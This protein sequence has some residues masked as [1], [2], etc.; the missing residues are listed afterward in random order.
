MQSQLTSRAMLLCGW[1]VCL[2]WTGCAKKTA[3]PETDSSASSAPIESE[4]EPDRSGDEVALQEAA[5]QE[6]G[7]NQLDWGTSKGTTSVAK[8]DRGVPL[9]ENGVGSQ[10]CVTC[11]P[12]RAQTFFETTHAKSLRLVDAQQEPELK[13]FYHA[14]SAQRM[15]VVR[16]GELVRHQSW[17]ELPQTDY[18]M[19]LA[20]H[21]I[22]LVMGS[23]TFAKSY[24]MRDGDALLQVP[25]SLYTEQGEYDMSPGYDSPTHF[26]FS[27]QVTDD[28]LFCHAGALSRVDGNRNV[29]VLHEL[30]IGCERCH[31][32]GRQHVDLA[33]QVSANS[34]NQ[35]DLGLVHDWAI[36]HPGE[37]GRDAMESLC[38]QCHLQGDVQ[39]FV[40]GA[41]S[42]SFRPGKDLAATR[43]VYNVGP[44]EKVSDS[45]TFVGHFGQMHASE[46]Y[47]GSD[48]LTCVSCHDPHQRVDESNREMIHRNHCLSCHDN[49][50]C[51]EEL[52]VRMDANE[53]SCHQCHMPRS[54]T[55]VPHVSITDHRIAVPKQR[56]EAEGSNEE[57]DETQTTELPTAVALLDR[58]PAG[59]WQRELNEATAIAQWLWMGSDPR[60]NNVDVFKLAADRL[61]SAIQAAEESERNPDVAN[62]S[63][64]EAKTRLA[65]L[66]D[67]V[68]L[69]PETERAE[70]DAT[71]LRKESQTLMQ[72]VLSAEKQPTPEVQVALES[73]ANLAAAEDRHLEAYQ[74]YQRLVKRR[75]NPADFYNLGLAC[76][77]LHRFGEAEQ[78]FMESIRIQPT[79]PLPYASLARL[80]Q[81]IDPRT[82][83]NYMQLSQRLR[84]VQQGSANRESEEQ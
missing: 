69:F 27:R 40:R 19:P 51:G 78:A 38:A 77:K 58:A 24:L 30:A 83:S 67:G 2:V 6:A 9:L 64:I 47:L 75:R 17:Q 29:S 42:W 8:P 46:C 52:T 45:T 84:L 82:A 63:L 44:P 50:D 80:Y 65:S 28:C 73:L 23:G 33:N 1:M 3:S 22:D 62:V 54:E 21:P 70:L 13:S 32:G 76:G 41:D 4:S 79:Y 55:E 35:T 43:L 7:P 61:R 5:L 74:L 26:G 60:F 68:L 16:D 14:P 37:L 25:L 39:M 59:S 31:G 57:L 71:R 48:S 56:T 15:K 36:V 49:M 53:N 11:H 20:D 66:L 81:A 12:N 34:S 18:V 10:A 72:W